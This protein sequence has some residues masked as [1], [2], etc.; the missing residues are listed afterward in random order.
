[1]VPRFNEVRAA[2]PDE[3]RG[4]CSPELKLCI[5]ELQTPVCQTPGDIIT[6]A[7]ADRQALHDACVEAGCLAA[8]AGSH[9]Y[10]NWQQLPY[11]PSEHYRW[12]KRETGYVSDRMMAFGLHIHVGMDT[13]QA[14][15]YCMH[16]LRRWVYPLAALFANSPFYEG[17]DT[18]LDSV[19][20]H[21]FGA[22]PRTGLPPDVAT[23]DDMQRLYDTLLAAQDVTAPG[24]LWWIMR[25]Q[26]PLGTLEI[27]AFDLP[28]QCEQLGVAAAL[29][30]TAMTHFRQNMLAGRE[31]TPLNDTFLRENLWKAMRHG[32]DTKI[33][34]AHT[35]EVLEMR[36]H[37]ARFFD[38]LGDTAAK[39]GNSEWLE[40]ARHLLDTGNG[41]TQQRRR[42]AA[43]N[44]DL[45]QLELDIAARSMQ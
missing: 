4:R 44:G 7:R 10:A 40:A 1:M 28:T 25:P 32:L 3:L 33:V 27:R 5:I 15:L 8:A 21:L 17:L 24:D 36:D 26:P 37:L 23:M 34:D 13:P 16:E 19:R 14:T 45:C 30:Q 42:A 29:C 39:L 20:L 9:P 31:R 11:I 2:L 18:G 43:C 12:V 35:A 6:H 41:A 22:M 38:M